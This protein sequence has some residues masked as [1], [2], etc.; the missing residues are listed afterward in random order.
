M[1]RYIAIARAR[2][3]SLDE[4]RSMIEGIGASYIGSIR[5]T[6]LYYKTSIGR[7]VVREI[8]GEDTLKLIYYAK[9]MSGIVTVF[10]VYVVYTRE[11]G[12]LKKILKDVLGTDAV[13]NISRDIYYLNQVEI[14]LDNV[15]KLGA[16]IGLKRM[17]GFKRGE[18]RRNIRLIKDLLEKLNINPDDLVDALYGDLLEVGRG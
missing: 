12:E 10:R 3:D 4:A 17:F 16:F 7:L 6:E 8:E 11:R 13:V 18:K 14:H 15:S 1:E 5:L 9:R 2:A